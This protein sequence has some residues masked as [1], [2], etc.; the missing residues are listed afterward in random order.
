MACQAARRASHDILERAIGDQLPHTIDEGLA[1]PFPSNQAER[2]EHATDLVGQINP[3]L[4]QAGT[5]GEQASDDLAVQA[6]DG[7]FAI[8]AG[9]HD[10]CQP[11]S[12]IRDRSCS[13][14][15]KCRFGMTSIEADHR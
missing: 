5:R 11:Q 1:A 14:A 7:D 13:P 10:L 3:H 4:D 2:F 15:A 9:A 8:P 6:F 12:I